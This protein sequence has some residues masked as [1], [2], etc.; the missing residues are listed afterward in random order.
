LSKEG[1]KITEMSLLGVEY[2]VYRQEIE[3]A[4]RVL[5]DKLRNVV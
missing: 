4:V 2:F 5:N 3:S 1:G